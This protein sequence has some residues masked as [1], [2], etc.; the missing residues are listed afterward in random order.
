MRRKKISLIGGG[1]IGGN[2]ALIA[3]QNEW[4]DVGIFDIP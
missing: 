1:Q 2:H 3:S 4:G